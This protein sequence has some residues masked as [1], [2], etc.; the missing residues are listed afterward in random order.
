M[1]AHEAEVSTGDSSF[2]DDGARQPI[3]RSVP[4]CLPHWL[5]TSRDVFQ[6]RKVRNVNY[7]NHDA[8]SVILIIQ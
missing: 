6:L 1:D 2:Q 8:N 3:N 5:K 4:K 7:S